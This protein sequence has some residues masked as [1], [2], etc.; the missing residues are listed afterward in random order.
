MYVEA[1]CGEA[2]VMLLI[3]RCLGA[4]HV[5]R[6]RHRLSHTPI[7]MFTALIILNC[8]VSSFYDSIDDQIDE[9]CQL[10]QTSHFN[11]NVIVIRNYFNDFCAPLERWRNVGGASEL[12]LIG[13]Q[14]EPPLP[15]CPPTANH[16]RSLCPIGSCHARH[17]AGRHE[18]FSPLTCPG[19][20]NALI[21][22]NCSWKTE[23]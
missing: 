6:S 16:D 2:I 7:I 9:S 19:F 4:L 21:V 18:D 20:E 8:L 13:G 23:S 5:V 12:V 10:T 14:E 1:S 17:C 11:C 15:R 3:Q 22:W